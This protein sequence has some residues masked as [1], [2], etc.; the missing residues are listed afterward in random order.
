MSIVMWIIMAGALAVLIGACVSGIRAKKQ[1][2]ET[3]TEV[4]AQ[5]QGRSVPANS[6]ADDLD[7]DIH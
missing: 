7:D 6:T 1:K 5:E 4:V 2:K 3:E